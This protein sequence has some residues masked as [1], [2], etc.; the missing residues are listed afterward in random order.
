[1]RHTVYKLFF[2]WD[3]KKEEKWLNE[4]SA[5]GMHLAGIGLCRYVFQEGTRGEYTYRIELLKELPSH[6]E[7]ISYIRFLEETGVEHIGSFMR[8][9]YLRKKTSDSVFDLYSDYKSRINHLK[10]IK[11]C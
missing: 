3:Y 1:M 4:M 7:S 5:K 2:A 10:R 9:I 11:F 8:W 6:P